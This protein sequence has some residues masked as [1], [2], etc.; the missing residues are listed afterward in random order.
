M[1]AASRKITCQLTPGQYRYAEKQTAEQ[2][3]PSD[4]FDDLL[5]GYENRADRW[6][7]HFAANGLLPAAAFEEQCEAIGMIVRGINDQFAFDV[8]GANDQ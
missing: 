7:E 6:G 5:T 8:G 3:Y 2:D 1:K 4:E